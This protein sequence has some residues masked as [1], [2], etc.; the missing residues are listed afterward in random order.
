MAKLF[1]NRPDN[2]PGKR[3]SPWP[4]YFT[5]SLGAHP[6]DWEFFSFVWASSWRG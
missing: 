6:L 4:A 3:F 5:R 2:R 1:S